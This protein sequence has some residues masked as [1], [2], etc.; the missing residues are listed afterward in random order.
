MKENNSKKNSGVQV[1]IH[2]KLSHFYLFLRTFVLLLVVIL[3]TIILINSPLLE[4][5]IP[6][7]YLSIGMLISLFYII[8]IRFF[9]YRNI[10]KKFL[11]Y[12]IMFDSKY[13][14]W[15]SPESTRPISWGKVIK[16]KMGIFSKIKITTEKKEFSIPLIV[17]RNH[18]EVIKFF[19][20]NK[21]QI[22]LLRFSR[23]LFLKIFLPLLFSIFFANNIASLSRVEQS[24]MI[25]SL[26]PGD[27]F[28]LDKL[29]YGLK[30]LPLKLPF[31]EIF[32]SVGNYNRKLSL[33]AI[34]RN[35]IIVF[36]NPNYSNPYYKKKQNKYLV[37]RVVA[38][39]CDLYRFQNNAI[40]INGKK[41]SFLKNIATKVKKYYKKNNYLEKFVP[42]FVRKAGRETIESFRSGLKVQGRV[43]RA[44]ALVLGDNRTHSMDSRDRSIG[45]IP[46]E[47]ISGRMIYN[48][49]NSSNRKK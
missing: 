21:R 32:P 35:D 2:K 7:L 24:S 42:K 14:R 20:G 15:T 28:V 40:Y 13:C 36:E 37:K 5:F 39:S 33:R 38:K 3:G 19:F 17:I 12:N 49:E 16:V 48:F 10:R 44:T 11:N 45:F 9:Y 6:S 26:Y 29:S 30:V 8:I 18:R 27:W 1:L 25:P 34:Q 4:S 41:E 43:P 22:H 47:L 46:Y 31:A 23:F